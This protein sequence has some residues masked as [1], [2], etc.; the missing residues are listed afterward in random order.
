L[1][2]KKIF[3][4]SLFISI[5]R[6][7]LFCAWSGLDYHQYTSKIRFNN[8]KKKTKQFL[9]HRWFSDNSFTIN[10][11]LI[12]Y[13]DL[14]NG[15]LSNSTLN[16][17]G[18]PLLEQI[19][20]HAA[21][22]VPSPLVHNHTCHHQ[23]PLPSSMNSDHEESHHH[24]SRKRKDADD[25]QQICEVHKLLD[26]WNRASR[27][28]FHSNKTFNIVQQMDTDSTAAVFQLTYG[29]PSLLIEMTDEQVNQFLFFLFLS[30]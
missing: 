30:F 15:I 9:V 28:R 5:R 22:S 13:L 1:F 8:N 2:D 26:E 25:D 3:S 19:A 29:I 10:K 16:L 24:H 23:T 20:H 11:N 21:D 7:I 27:N 17:H 4:I 18:S 6:S 12:S 14:G